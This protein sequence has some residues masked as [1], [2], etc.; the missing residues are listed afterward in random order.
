[1]NEF[2][3]IIKLTDENGMDENFEFLDLVQY[4]DNMYVV[5]LPCDEPDDNAQVVILKIEDTDTE[6]KESYIS[7]EDQDELMAVFSI[8]KEKFKDE[9]SFIDE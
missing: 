5:L 2:D 9:F 7:V 8:F 6:D 4:D 1:M 3:N